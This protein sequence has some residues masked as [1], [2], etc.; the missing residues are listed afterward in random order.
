MGRRYINIIHTQEDTYITLS[1]SYTYK[2]KHINTQST[3]TCMYICT[4]Q[5]ENFVYKGS[6]QSVDNKILIILENGWTPV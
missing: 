2:V 1:P 3:C 5:R 4:L 6:F